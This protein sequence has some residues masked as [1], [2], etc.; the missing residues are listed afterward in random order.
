VDF[1]ESYWNIYFWI[2]WR[3][4]KLET[5]TETKSMAVPSIKATISLEEYEKVPSDWVIIDLVDKLRF[6][7]S[8]TGKTFLLDN[9]ET[10]NRLIRES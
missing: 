10:F 5:K 4:V 6:T 1:A 3:G 8:V 7:N 9:L 2:K